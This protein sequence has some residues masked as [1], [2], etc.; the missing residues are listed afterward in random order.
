MSEDVRLNEEQRK[1]LKDAVQEG[2][3]SFYR[4][5]AEKDLRKEIAERVKD[6]LGVEKKI[7]NKLVKLA[8]RDACRQLNQETTELLDL[9]EELGFYSHSED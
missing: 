6:E 2:V 4:E 5:Q 3:N 9:A 8:Y 7:Y 1:M